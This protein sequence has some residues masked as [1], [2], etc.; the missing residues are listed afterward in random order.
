MTQY[1]KKHETTADSALS[2]LSRR[3]LLKVTILGIGG[4][5][6]SPLLT[7]SLGQAA[8]DTKKKILIV[9]FSRTGHT[10]SIAEQ[11]QASIGGDI[12]ELKTAHSYPEE[13]K[14]TIDQAERE[15]KENFRP[16]LITDVESVQPYDVI[17]IG[18]PN[19]W[20]TM[21][22]ALFS[23]LEKHDFSGKTL[24]PFC[25]HGGSRLGRSPSDIARLCPAATLLDGF[26]VRG[27]K[28]SDAQRDVDAWLRRIGLN[29]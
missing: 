19:W 8:E 3:A 5:L 25:T 17:F 10:R 27:T 20:G 13:Y 28:A 6:F 14:A 24:V 26:A 12:L 4:L 7:A 18:Y 16:T 2:T 15:Q 9:Y 29:R 21:P 11:I 23:F 1:A 22:M